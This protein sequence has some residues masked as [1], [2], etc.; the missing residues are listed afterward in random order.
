LFNFKIGV[1]V[2]SKDLENAIAPALRE[3]PG[4]LVLQERGVDSPAVLLEKLERS[5]P[6]V[7]L[8]D[9][10]QVDQSIEDTIRLIKS[11]SSNP[12]VIV[13][14]VAAEPATILQCLRAG[15]DE[16]LYP[17]FEKDLRASLD[18]ML[19]ERMK[20][21]A[22]ATTRGKVLGFLSVKGGCGATTLAC[23]LSPQIARLTSLDVL[24]ADFDL[25]GG[26]IGFLMKSQCRYSIM[27]AVENIHR[28]DLSFWKALVSNGIPGVEVMMAPQAGVSV[29][30]IYRNP[31]EYRNVLRFARANYDWTIADLGRNLNYQT[32]SVF[33][34]LDHL[35]LVTTMDV[36]ALHQA[37]AIVGCLLEK[38]FPA[39]RLQVIVN[40]MQKNSEL[41]LDEVES[42]L[43]HAVFASLPDDHQALN[44][45]YSEGTLVS[46]GGLGD[47]FIRVAGKITGVETKVKKRFSLF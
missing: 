14:H 33:E 22:G 45:A 34:E 32:M 2:G 12:K 29:T 9:L 39:H 37:K 7:V 17:P 26:I 21:Q 25:E 4:Q 13:L 36:P 40:Q 27:D 3:F 5:R 46:Q 11:A 20:Q 15:A 30:R 19:Q 23:H 18:R 24:L 42:M 1:V 35:Y 31:D 28:L 41:N 43:G 44:E 38:G 8:L 16:F 6:D 10:S 47:H